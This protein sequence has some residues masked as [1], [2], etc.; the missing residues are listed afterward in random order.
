MVNCKRK[1]FFKKVLDKPDKVQYIIITK[2]KEKE[3][4]KMVYGVYCEGC[5][6]GYG[7]TFESAMEIAGGE[8]C[9]IVMMERGEA[10]DLIC[11]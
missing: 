6:Y 1:N 9:E 3:I 10:E 11:D 5:F 7:E 8:M 2:G 4:K